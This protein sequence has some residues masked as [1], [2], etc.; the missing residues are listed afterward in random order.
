MSVIGVLFV[1]WS[2]Y[3][4]NSFTTPL[5]LAIFILALALPLQS[6]LQNWLWKPLATVVT[7]SV[8][9]VIFVLLSSITA[10]AFGNL[11]FT[12]SGNASKYQTLY[13]NFATWLE[14]R[15]IELAALWADSV[16]IN[17]VLRTA[18]QLVS[19]MSQTAGFWV[20]VLAY[21]LTGLVEAERMERSV[22]RL[23]KSGV[24]S[25]L[26]RGS[27]DM[28]RKF[29]RYMVVR[30]LVS[31]ATGLAISLFALATR[32]PFPVEWGVIGFVFNFIPFIGPLIA[33]VFP[34]LF[35]LAHMGDPGLAVFAFALLTI[36]QFVIGNYIEPRVSGDALQLSPFVIL[37][38]IF[39]WTFI[40]GIYG[41]FIGV[42][43]AIAVV[44]FTD[45]VSS[46][47]WMARLMAAEPAPH[48]D[49]SA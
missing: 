9:L 5:T 12:V 19:R 1:L 2:A 17:V 26:I 10:W 21:V 8:I 41:T 32:I 29:R 36:N 14:E 31:A 30:S 11:W 28:A 42:P 25:I 43:I 39:L 45:Q 35:I 7:L 15:G 33:T 16:N 47:R 38:A 27:V 48:T 20:V 34:S 24:S 44:S 23:Q 13:Q 4:A 46:T 6:I 37:V 22:R 40:W 49:G 3:F 18:Q